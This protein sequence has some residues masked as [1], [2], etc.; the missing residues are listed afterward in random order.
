[1]TETEWKAEV[2]ALK[3]SPRGDWLSKTLTA[4]ASP[5]NNSVFLDG[6]QT[7]FSPRS[8]ATHNLGPLTTVS[9]QGGANLQ[10]GPRTTIKAVGAEQ[11]ANVWAPKASMQTTKVFSYGVVGPTSAGPERLDV[12]KAFHVGGSSGL[13]AAG[14][15]CATSGSS[16]SPWTVQ[17]GKPPGGWSVAGAMAVGW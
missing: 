17:T 9:R 6:R 11:L 1:M 4:K 10:P 16:S 14:V 7:M 15:H 13:V 8:A 5:R 2:A 12:H 3:S